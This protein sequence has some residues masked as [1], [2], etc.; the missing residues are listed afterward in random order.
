MPPGTLH[1][2][3]SAGSAA[4]LAHA[5]QVAAA[6][7]AAAQ[8]V[9][10]QA[11]LQTAAGGSGV[12]DGQQ[13]FMQLSPGN[14]APVTIA[15][16]PGG[17]QMQLVQLAPGQPIPPGLQGG[18]VRVMLYT[19]AHVCTHARTHA[20]ALPAHHATMPPH[21][22]YGHNMDTSPLC[23]GRARARSRASHPAPLHTRRRMSRLLRASSRP[24]S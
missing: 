15:T 7:Q 18:Q 4:Q 14:F 22:P 12:G 17:Q 2:H 20:R 19:H 13:A 9:G 8:A 23:C 24:C 11:G 10:L 6:Q 21:T 3:A 1:P 5:V 16:N